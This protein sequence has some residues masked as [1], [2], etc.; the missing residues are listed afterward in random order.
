M[1]SPTGSEQL[2]SLAWALESVAG[3]ARS[4]AMKATCNV[5]GIAITHWEACAEDRSWFVGDS[6]WNSR[7][8]IQCLWNARFANLTNVWLDDDAWHIPLWQLLLPE[9]RMIFAANLNY[10]IKAHG[11]GSVAQL[12]K[13]IGRNTTT[14][15]KWGRW[16]EEG[17]K[18]RLPPATAMP[19]IL[20]F[21]GL[22]PSCDLYEDPLFLGHAEI[23]DAL[24]R[25]EGRHY[26]ESLSG[27]YL[28]QAVDRLR[29]E[30]ARQATSRR[31]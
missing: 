4:D 15:S 30:S 26:L 6:R 27:E 16:R 11:R 25:I 20:E 19:R 22:K 13:F 18:V 12:A 21:F 3:F 23:R 5:F 8:Q 29:E 1:T 28:R 9:R 24:L 17:R 2:L 7:E 10:L 14:A 31:V